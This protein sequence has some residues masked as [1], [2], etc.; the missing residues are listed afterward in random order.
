MVRRFLLLAK[1]KLSLLG[2]KFLQGFLSP[3]ILLKIVLLK[4]DLA[5]TIASFAR[6][7]SGHHIRDL[8]G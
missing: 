4:E 1:A 8:F 6:H 3:Q 2:V 7:Q 5:E